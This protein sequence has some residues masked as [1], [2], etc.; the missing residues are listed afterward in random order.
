MPVSNHDVKMDFIGV[1]VEGLC[2]YCK[3]IYGKTIFNAVQES[4]GNSPSGE[5][6]NKSC[7]DML[8]CFFNGVVTVSDW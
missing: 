2:E 3:E 1:N 6:C 5:A 7:S 8:G 4:I